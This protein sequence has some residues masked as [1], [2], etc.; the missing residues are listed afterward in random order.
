MTHSPD[1]SGALKACSVVKLPPVVSS[2]RLIDHIVALTSPMVTV[3]WSP[4]L[5]DAMAPS[6]QAAMRVSE[7]G[8]ISHQGQT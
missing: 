4:A 6:P 1:D 8:R 7:A 3:T 2:T 5:T